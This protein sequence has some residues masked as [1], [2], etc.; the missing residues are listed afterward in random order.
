[1]L[2]RQSICMK[3]AVLFRE[4]KSVRTCRATAGFT[5]IEL[6]VV[7]AIIAILAAM[8]LPALASAKER[9][10]RIQCLNG[11]RQLHLGCTIYA[12]D[13]DDL[14]PPWGAAN[15]ATH[16]LNKIDLSNYIRWILT[17]SS[18]AL[19][20]QHIPQDSRTFTAAGFACENMGYLYPAKLAGDGRIFFCPSFP[21]SSLIGLNQYNAG[22]NIS[23]AKPLI[24]S[25]ADVRGGYT[26]NP[27]IDTNNTTYGTT[28][29]GLR[30]SQKSSQV[31]AHRTFIMDYLD[32]QMN[33]SGY[34]AHQKSKGWNIS[35]TDGST[36]FSRPDAAT[37]TKIAAGGYPAN[38]WQMNT[39]V[40]P[41]LEA[42][43][44]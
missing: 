27:V 35:Y 31:G 13:S 20:G 41:I 3:K 12:T 10:K 32:S 26:Y 21:D 7:I 37:Y 6:L 19:S 36:A 44:K 43:A 25:S 30:L 24:N 29:Y 18:T 1:M 17:G 34:F 22:G 42:N 28:T 40:I 16:P 8:L 23:W 9:A 11:L 38:I 15:N 33:Q 39:E 2:Y 5:L 4:S 14:F